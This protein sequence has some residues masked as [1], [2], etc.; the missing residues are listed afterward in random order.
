MALINDQNR[1]WIILVA[2]SLAFGLNM[3]DETVVAIALPT[4]Q[5]D[6]SM[7]LLSSHWILNAYLL[8]IAVF[9]AVGG[10]LGDIAG[11]RVIF[12]AG[13]LLFGF[14]SLAAG[15]AESTA[16]ILTARAF[17]GLGAAV[18]FP[19]SFA[20]IALAFPQSQRGVAI[21]I[22]GGIGT[23]FLAMGP[24]LGGLITQE[25]SWRWIF[26]V[27]LPV[28]AV[29][30]I[31]FLAAWREPKAGAAR[32][33]IDFR[34]LIT[35]VLGTCALILAIMQGPEW[36]WGSFKIIFL[37]IAAAI[38]IT[39]FWLFELSVEEPLIDVRL[40]RNGTFTVSNHLLFTAQFTKMSVFVFVA[41]YFQTVLEM[42]PLTAGLAFLPAVALIP[43]TSVLVGRVLNRYGPRGPG[44]LGLLVSGVALVV[45]GISLETKRYILILPSL[46]VWSVFMTML[47]PPARFG[48]MNSVS[49]EKQGQVGGIGITMQI[50][51]GTIGL[52]VLSVVIRELDSYRAVMFTSA[53]VAFAVLVAGWFYLER[54][55]RY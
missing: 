20:L 22:Y 36:G 44:L 2:A 4:I 55:V 51:G 25:I 46:M 18:I 17:Q 1:K 13:L 29:I 53:F 31:A 3:L 35:L 33:S 28:V 6:L 34:G 16:W 38:F 19:A 7:T 15:F 9:V 30:T 40:F 41:L 52:A 43:A 32:P 21:G 23:S 27:N 47:F 50:L 48:L 5:R 37:F 26:W 8:V 45:M 24:F 54:G 11:Y 14:S 12:A 49:A 10:K 39:A 42:D